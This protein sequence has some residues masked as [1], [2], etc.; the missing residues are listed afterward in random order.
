MLDE[1]M[2]VGKVTNG[3]IREKSGLTMEVWKKSG[4]RKTNS[5]EST[6]E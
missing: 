5:E 4:E 3:E 1:T 2:G 6:K